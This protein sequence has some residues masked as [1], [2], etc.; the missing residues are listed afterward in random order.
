MLMNKWLFYVLPVIRL[1][2]IRHV[3][4][5]E[6]A[7]EVDVEAVEEVEVDFYFCI[8][9]FYEFSLCSIYSRPA[10]KRGHPLFTIVLAIFIFKNEVTLSLPVI[11]L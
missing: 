3:P 6:E 7:E 1:P 4:V 8:A 5:G 10:Q 9:P 11:S 2:V